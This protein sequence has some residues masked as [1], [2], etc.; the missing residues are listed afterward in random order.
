[1]TLTNS[2]YP[3]CPVPNQNSEGIINLMGIHYIDI[4]SYAS[5]KINLGEY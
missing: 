2:F 1:M 3:E 5:F 4:E